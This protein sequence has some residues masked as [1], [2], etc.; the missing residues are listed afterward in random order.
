[1]STIL[2]ALALTAAFSVDPMIIEVDRGRDELV[3]RIE[4]VEALPEALESAFSTGSRVAI[5]Y[6]LRIYARRR[7]FPDRKIW[8]G[9][10][11]S[12]VAFDAVTGR[13][14]CQLIVNGATTAS[15][16]VDSAADAH[17]WLVAPPVVEVQIPE[18]RREAFLR[19]RARA[20]FSS[21]TTWLVFPSTEGTGW[22][23]MRLE[24]PQNDE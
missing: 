12:A 10:V 4:L 3:I 21:G 20:V 1:M 9:V 13:Y 8:K 14:L 7:M 18:A 2:C 5:D 15:R 16:E 22:V 6:P 17:R 19:V 24:A 11:Q 23:E